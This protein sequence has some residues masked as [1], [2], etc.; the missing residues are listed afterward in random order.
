VVAKTT[1]QNVVQKVRLNATLPKAK[2]SRTNTHQSALEKT[3]LLGNIYSTIETK[4]TSDCFYKCDKDSRC[5][6]ASFTASQCNL[7]KFGFVQN[8][9]ANPTDYSSYIKLEVKMAMLKSQNLAD[10]FPFVQ[11][12]TRYTSNYDSFDALTPLQCFKTCKESDLCAA[13]SFTT[14]IDMPFNCFFFEQGMFEAYEDRTM[15]E[16]WTSWTRETPPA[17]TVLSFTTTK[18]ILI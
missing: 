13:A 3:R 16:T 17:T 10:K 14:N 9:S 8:T 18:V 6:A 12:N 15:I 1:Q 7:H 11:Y 5:A 4:Q 2:I